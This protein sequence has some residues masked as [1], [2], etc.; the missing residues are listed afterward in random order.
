MKLSSVTLFISCFIVQFGFCQLTESKGPNS[1]A[2][3]GLNANNIDVWAI[4]YNVGQLENIEAN[5]IGISF[6]QP[7]LLN[8]L[9]TANLVAA[10]KTSKGVFGLNYANYG[11]EF[12]QINTTGIGYSMKLGENLD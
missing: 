12:Y 5:T 6:Y 3:A 7:F 4:N 11:N 1:T 8:D 9:S 10:I 2:M